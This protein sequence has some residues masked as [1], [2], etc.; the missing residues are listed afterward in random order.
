M[1]THQF[2][3]GQVVQAKRTSHSLPCG[4]FRIIRLLPAA[5]DGVPLYCI[6]GEHESAERIVEQHQIEA[7]TL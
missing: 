5:A 7:R 3:I 1:T 2:K 4:P 6:K